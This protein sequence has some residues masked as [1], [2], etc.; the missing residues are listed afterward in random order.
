MKGVA[1]I[2]QSKE[3]YEESDLALIDD[4]SWQSSLASS[5]V[6]AAKDVRKAVRV[7]CTAS[8][9]KGA[10]SAAVFAVQ[11]VCDN[12]GFSSID[13]ARAAQTRASIAQSHAIHVP[14][15][16]HEANSVKRHVELELANDVKCWNIH[17]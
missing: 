1:G 7:A 13:A 6:A 11:N 5:A 15:V 10:A 8:N 16:E 3:V 12:R 9:A 2:G 17:R 4:I 14:V